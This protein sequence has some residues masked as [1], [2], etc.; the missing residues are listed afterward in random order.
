MVAGYSVLFAVSR[1][2]TEADR[3]DRHQQ[4]VQRIG[5]G[6]QTRAISL[7]LPSGFG[8]EAQWKTS[9][10]PDG[11]RRIQR[12]DGSTWLVTRSDFLSSVDGQRSL[13]IRQN[14]T[15]SVQRG[16]RDLI[17]RMPN[18]KDDLRVGN[19]LAYDARRKTLP[20]TE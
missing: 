18:E 16:E 19:L 1:G 2:I 9:A 11:T 10:Q 5:R 14:I 4:L 6:L 3:L 15:A 8:V 20:A 13:E 7:P 12:Q 17:V